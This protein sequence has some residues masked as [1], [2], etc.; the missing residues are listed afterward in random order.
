MKNYRVMPES[1]LKLDK[2]DHDDTGE[3]KKTEQGKE[4]AR[5]ITADLI[6]KLD[7]LQERLYANANCSLL[8]LL[9]G[10]DTSG[11]D[12]TI[13]HVMSGVNPQCCRVTTFKAPSNNEL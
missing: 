1:Q 13:K 3:Y 6:A 7:G 4:K 5:T 2:Y 9:Q 8:I 11:K 10:L 12:G